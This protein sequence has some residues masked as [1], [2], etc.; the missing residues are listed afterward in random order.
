VGNRYF[1]RYFET[2]GPLVTD[3]A[4]EID[5]LRVGRSQRDD[6]AD[7]GLKGA[8]SVGEPMDAIVLSR[9]DPAGETP[10]PKP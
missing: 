7:F 8:S 1:D 10:E 9:N 5:F 2:P 6:G 4:R 3:G